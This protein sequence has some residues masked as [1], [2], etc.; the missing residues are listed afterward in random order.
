MTEG[1]MQALHRELRPNTAY[2]EIFTEFYIIPK[3][4]SQKS[5]FDRR[6]KWSDQALTLRIFP[7]TPSSFA[8]LIPS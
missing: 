8:D 1:R 2:R 6:M 3:P 5:F 4:R 7:L